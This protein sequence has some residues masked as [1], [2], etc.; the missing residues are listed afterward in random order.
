MT[1][2]FAA[3]ANMCCFQTPAPTVSSVVSVSTPLPCHSELHTDSDLLGGQPGQSASCL[4]AL[5][6]AQTPVHNICKDLRMIL[7]CSLHPTLSQ[8]AVHVRCLS[9]AKVAFFLF[10]SQTS[11]CARHPLCLESLP[12]PLTCLVL[13][14]SPLGT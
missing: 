13:P 3:P 11:E 9:T 8:A 1:S 14:N 5:G 12:L 6:K 10:L 4:K 2:A 7:L